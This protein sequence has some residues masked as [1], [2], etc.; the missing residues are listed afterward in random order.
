MEDKYHL[1]KRKNI[2]E[3]FP[4]KK[5]KIKE[6]SKMNRLT[7]YTALQGASRTKQY[8]KHR[9]RDSS[10]KTLP[11]IQQHAQ[12]RKLLAYTSFKDYHRDHG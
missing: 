8:T 3:L 1:G 9:E 7:P 4:E 2:G 6:K 12:R 11:A 5:R 10:Y